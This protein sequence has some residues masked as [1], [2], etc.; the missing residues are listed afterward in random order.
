LNNTIQDVDPLAE[1]IGSKF[2]VIDVRVIT[3]P[4]NNLSGILRIDIECEWV[5][6]DSCTLEESFVRLMYAFRT[7][8]VKASIAENVPA[9]IHTL[10]MASFNA[11]HQ[12]GMIVVF[13]RDVR[14]Y[15][16]EKINGNQ[17]GARIIRIIATP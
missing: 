13:W 1:T 16:D 8:Q 6:S 12:D 4:P 5:Y 11:M 3:E 10:Q 7:D 15:M 14:D 2:K 17:L 9:T